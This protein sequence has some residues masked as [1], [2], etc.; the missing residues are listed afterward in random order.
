MQWLK[1]PHRASRHLLLL[2]LSFTSLTGV[3]D[4]KRWKESSGSL[5]KG[6]V[7]DSRHLVGSVFYCLVILGTPLQADERLANV[8]AE[9]KMCHSFF[10]PVRP[11]IR[12]YLPPP[13]LWWY[14]ENIGLTK[15]SVRITWRCQD[16]ATR[17]PLGVF[18]VPFGALMM[19][20]V[21]SPL[22]QREHR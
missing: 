4:G 19:E 15:Q 22:F 17:R 7:S 9:L 10:H 14:H 8:T 18:P 12:D 21:L 2:D 20:N 11:L 1:T 5:N 16:S 3:T 13:F 6:I